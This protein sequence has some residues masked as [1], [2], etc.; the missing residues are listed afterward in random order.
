MSDFKQNLCNRSNTKSDPGDFYHQDFT[1]RVIFGFL[2]FKEGM[3]TQLRWVGLRGHLDIRD[4]LAA[5][6]RMSTGLTLCL[7]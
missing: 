5:P 6:L 4:L 1:Q 3:K 7:A 2:C